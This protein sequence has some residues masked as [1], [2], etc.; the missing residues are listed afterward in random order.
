M[1]ASVGTQRKQARLRKQHE[2]HRSDPNTQQVV[3]TPDTQD[4]I[5][6]LDTSKFEHMQ[7]V[8]TVMANTATLPDSLRFADPKNKDPFE[9]DVL[10]ATCFRIVNQAVRWGFDPFAVSDCAFI[11]HGRLGWEKLVHAVIAAKTGINLNHRFFDDAKGQN[12]GVLVSGTLQKP[13]SGR[14]RAALGL[15]YWAKRPMG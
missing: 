6:V 11:I 14:S 15:A 10:V 1:Q 3:D 12:M 2:Q 13:K 5:P 8:A 4:V 7:R 9:H